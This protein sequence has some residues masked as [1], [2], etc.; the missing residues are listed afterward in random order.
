MRR[1]L[2][3]G[4]LVLLPAL[5]ARAEDEK[6]RRAR[7][8]LERDVNALVDIP[9]PRVE[10][11]FAGPAGEGYTLSEATFTL[12]DAELVTPSPGD[13]AQQNGRPIFQGD[14]VP[15]TRAL[16]ISLLY[17]QGGGLFS[18]MNGFKYKLKAKFTFLVQRGLLVRVKVRVTEDAAAQD[19]AK[20]LKL[21][22][23][24]GAE[25]IAKL[26]DGRMPPAPKPTIALTENTVTVE[27]A[28]AKSPEP[29]VAAAVVPA[30]AKAPPKQKAAK[31]A[32]ATVKAPRKVMVAKAVERP[33]AKPAPAAEPEPVA[34]PPPAP[35][36][37]P[38]AAAV[39]P[40]PAPPAPAPPAPPAV[41]APPTP[42]APARSGSTLWIIAGLAA[43]AAA[44]ALFALRRRR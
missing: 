29:A 23:S 19:P 9:A 22:V 17:T 18:Y 36:P 14:V 20:R 25:M 33:V 7:E 3:M 15:G 1:V 5:G 13:L 41:A 34:A 38:V 8:E 44:I 4:L 42:P 43:A 24:A 2:L 27:P 10:L 6:A 39:A 26:E 12:D 28:A 21:G 11:Q 31:L 30:A 40:E 32:V 16:N 37:E 35:A